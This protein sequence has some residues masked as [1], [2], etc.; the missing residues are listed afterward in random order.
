M[1]KLIFWLLLGANAL[2]FAL[3]QGYLGSMRAGEHEPERVNNQL[4]PGQLTLVSAAS[5]TAAASQPART[6]KPPAVTPCTE[7][8]DFLL[9]EAR[10]FETRL[11]VLD[12]G[13]RQARRNVPGQEV[14][15][16]IV[17][18][19]PQGSKDAADKKAA[20]LK[21][22]GVKNY[23]V[24]SDSTPLRWGISLGVF[25]QEAGAQNMLAAL[26]KQGVHSARVSPRYSAS[27]QLVFQFRDLTGAEKNRLGQIADGFPDQEVRGCK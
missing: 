10:R 16:Y 20:E 8:G 21:Q 3:A 14:S 12:L 15:S 13:E 11:E 23:F 25:K 4:N 26:N 17:Y 19:P 5:A 9:A 22:L 27:K 18:I 7:V 2:L 1:L 6:P 24:I